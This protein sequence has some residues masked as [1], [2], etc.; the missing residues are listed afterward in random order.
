VLHIAEDSVEFLEDSRIQEL[1]NKYC[2][3]M[4]VPIQFGTKDEYKTVPT[5]KKDK[6][7]KEETKQEKYTVDNIINNPEPAWVKTPS[8]LKEEDYKAFYRELY[9]MNFEDPLFNIHLNVDYPFNLTGILYFP[10]L[11]NNMELPKDRIQ[12]YCNQVFVT[13]SVEGIVPDFLT[14]LRGV[15]DSPDIPLNVSRSYLQADSNVKKISN[16]ITKK[17]AD[18]LYE[19]FNNNREDF[20]KKWDDI[21]VF[22]EYGMLSEEKF[23]EKAVKFA[24]YKDTDGN[25]Y[26][27][28]EL[29]E[30][31]KPI[32]TDKDGQLVYLYTSNVDE[33][34]AYIEEAKEK[35]YT[36]L[37]LDSQ[38]TGHFVQHL[39]QKLEKSS[40]VRVDG[41]TIDKLIKKDEEIPSKLSEEDEKTLKPIFEAVVP[42]E[43]FTVQFESLSEKSNPVS[44]TRSEFMRRMQEM[45]Q[46][47]GGGMMMGNMPEMYNLVVN[48]NHPLI[49]KILSEK[50]ENKK[51]ELS[52]Q[53]TDL[54][55]LSQNLLKGEELTQFIKRSINLIH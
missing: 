10:K 28:E 31:L 4:P 5:G 22:I 17:V 21:K 15:I 11:K 49:G 44:V 54:A 51:K 34:H 47:G 46:M 2:K 32:Q 25:Y 23:Y 55:L 35:G 53:A 8:N 48:A 24:L 18:K 20:Q 50:D 36:V 45:S 14:L 6:D 7:G 29:T 27:M 42:K 41:D 40:F 39:E 19:L 16:H 38:L 33:Q 26:T 12:L 13:D 1:L 52:K 3:F 30:K 9:P 43:K 37:L